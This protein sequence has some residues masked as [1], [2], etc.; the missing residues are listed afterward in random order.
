MYSLYI[1]SRE[2]ALRLH[3]LM[4]DKRFEGRVDGGSI[5]IYLVREGPQ[6]RSAAGVGSL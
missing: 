3:L 4:Q 1:L 5:G 2:E 6:G